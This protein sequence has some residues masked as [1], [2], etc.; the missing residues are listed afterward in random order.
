MATSNLASAM[1]AWNRTRI[2]S[3]ST[4]QEVSQPPF[5][6]ILANGHTGQWNLPWDLPWDLPFTPFTP[7]P[8]KPWYYLMSS[9][10][11]SR[12]SGGN[13]SGKR[14]SGKPSKGAQRSVRKLI[15]S[16]ETH[17]VNTLTELC[18]IERFAASCD[19]EDDAR[20]FQGP[21]T[22][23]WD[24]YVSSN[25]F[26]TEL[27]GL[28]RSYPICSD[29]IYAAEVRVRSDPDS[30]RSWN[31]AWLLLRKMIGDDLVASFASIEAAK[32]E[33]WGEMEPTEE[34]IQQLAA[35]F[36]YEWNRAVTTMLRHWAASPRWC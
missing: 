14:D 19:D 6:A 5:A 24:Y 28:T 27:R 13:S 23:A 31:L 34:E 29:I 35:C 21:M 33:M 16:L 36:E 15:E 2:F 1:A 10:G 7:Q 4:G 32:P 8:T 30:N 26:L 22:A 18:R 25:Q 9:R 3:T 12:G 11:S 20:A 17:R